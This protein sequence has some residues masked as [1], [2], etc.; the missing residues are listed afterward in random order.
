M[1]IN[2]IIFALLLA[3]CSNPFVKEKL[4]E[5]PK[6]NIPADLLQDCD[7]I[8][9]LDSSTMGDLLKH[10]INLMLKYKECSVRHKR[11]KE[12]VTK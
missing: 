1:K 3:S 8:D 5:T 12:A 11:L 7:K 6:V 10:D 4:Q 9:K 2:Y